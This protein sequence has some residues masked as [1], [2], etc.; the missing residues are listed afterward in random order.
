MIRL[1][2]VTLCLLSTSAFAQT[3][4]DSLL[5]AEYQ[6]GHFNGAVLVVK[7]GKV[8]A[9][10]NKGYAN[11]QFAVPITNDTRFP[12]A[13]MT[14]TFTALLVL[15]LYEK[16]LLQLDDKA[17]RY[18]P[19]LPASCQ[20]ISLRDLLTHYSGLKNEPL[21]AYKA[22]YTPA[23]YSKQFVVAQ[24]AGKAP[25]FNYNNVDYVLLTRV[26]EAVSKKS[27]AKLLQDNIFTPLGMSYSGLVRE[28]VI[29]P[30]LANGY[31]NY[32]FGAGK[33]TDTLFADSPSYLSNYAGAGA[34]YSTPEDLAK[35]VA[36]LHSHRLI[37]TKTTAAF[38]LKPQQPTYID[39]IRGYP[40]LGFYYNDK[41]FAQPMLER[42]GSINGFNSVLLT[43]K[44][45]TKAVIILT[46]TDTADLEALGD[47]VYTALQ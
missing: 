40:T 18:L 20:A 15:Q 38:L 32:T 28:S 46:N 42:R 41:T 45:F 19:D 33:K 9:Q 30:F 29:T 37:S 11:F 21:Q 14:K 22:K 44:Q 6:A 24:E 7:D 36:A 27:Y 23:E 47:K 17:A 34:L 39:G 35:L 13:S 5:E 12:I 1:L 16:G 3:R 43:N 26:I 31:H 2:L 4:L 10:R 25:A 8:A